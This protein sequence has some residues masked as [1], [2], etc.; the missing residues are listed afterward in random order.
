MKKSRIPGIKSY[1]CMYFL[2][3]T[4]KEIYMEICEVV[5]FHH[6]RVK[7]MTLQELHANNTQALMRDSNKTCKQS[8]VI[9]TECQV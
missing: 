5:R 2:C 3:G 4:C 9:K 8:Q 6:S 1:A 7:F